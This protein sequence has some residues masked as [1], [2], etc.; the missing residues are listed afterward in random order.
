MSTDE[1]ILEELRA[2]RMLLEAQAAPIYIEQG[3]QLATASKEERK[4]WN[5][6]VLASVKGKM[7][8]NA[9]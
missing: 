2:I 1:Q 5:K 8:K 3:R 6:Q 7:R 9:A 4:A